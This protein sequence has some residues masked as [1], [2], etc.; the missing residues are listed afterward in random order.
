MENENILVLDGVSR[1]YPDFA[2]QDISF[3]IPY[4]TVMGFIGENGA[5]KSTTIKLILDIVRRDA[6]RIRLFGRD[7][8]P[9]KELRE[10]VGV[11]FGELNLPEMM[12]ALQIS[13]IM[14]GIYAGWQENTF[15]DLLGRFGLKKEMKIKAYSRGMKMKLAIA[16]ALSHD[17][18]LLLLDEPTSGLDPVVRDEI[19]DIF[20]DFMQDEK[21]GILISSHITED[22]QK[23]ADYITLIHHGKLLFCEEKDLLLDKYRILRASEGVLAGLPS[24]AVVG[25]R[26][27]RFGVE[28]LVE[29]DALNGIRLPENAAADPAEL[30]DIM[31]YHVKGGRS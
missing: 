22:L 13:R 19:L 18:Q 24:G 5:G 20:R 9:G 30:Q 15:S 1:R 2:L 10:K 27:N 26:P 28:A 17:A 7:N 21:H 6:G 4:G 3:Q 16:I 23:I 14:G 11:V 25:S 29:A 12:N 31:L 8:R